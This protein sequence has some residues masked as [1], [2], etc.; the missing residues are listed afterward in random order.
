MILISVND[1][2]DFSGHRWRQ[3]ALA[4]VASLPPSE[5][6][7]PEL[8]RLGSIAALADRMQDL[9][10]ARIEIREWHIFAPA[11][12]YGFYL[13]DKSYPEQL[14]EAD[15]RKLTPPFARNA[16][17]YLHGPYGAR[18]LAP[19]LTETFAIECF[20][21]YDAPDSEAPS[22]VPAWNAQ[23]DST[24]NSSADLYDAAFD[25][26]QVRSLEFDFVVSCLRDL[27]TG[28][29]SLPRVLDV[30][31]GNGQMLI[32][33]LVNS[34]IT[35]AEGIDAAENMIQH[36]RRRSREYPSLGFQLCENA[37]F[38][39]PDDSFDAIVSF[40]SFRYLDWNAVLPEIR[41]VLR[42]AGRFILVDMAR[43][44]LYW[45]ERPGYWLTKLRTLSLHRNQPQFAANLKRLVSD[46]TWADMLKYHPM[47]LSS[48]YEYFLR[49]RF[50]K[51]RW[52]S[53]Y[54]CYDHKLFGFVAELPGTGEV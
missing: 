10:N 46:P 41:R 39:F 28:H 33:L 2:F 42:P 51:S 48:E 9:R 19:F 3:A 22:L 32:Q 8:H 45:W 17:V 16:R 50:A 12:V 35:S 20:G 49:S 36:A 6:P 29:D 37:H 44:K 13:G 34:T 40:M 27:R 11:G 52:E 23:G 25:D 43:S 1:R 14:G 5:R 15:W 7:T 21:F 18:W 53:L 4:F 54:A 38:P 24:Y 31:C 47:R 30:G 26:I